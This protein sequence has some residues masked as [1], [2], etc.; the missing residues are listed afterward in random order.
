MIGYIGVVPERRGHGYAYD[1]LVEG[2]Q[3]LAAE[4]VDRIVAATDSTNT[5][6][7]A[8]FAKAGYPITSHVINLV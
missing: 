7:A 2:T 1:L 6:M 8:A 4:G 5:P 3:L